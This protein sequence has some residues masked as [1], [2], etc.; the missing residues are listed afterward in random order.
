MRTY[1]EKYLTFRKR[2]NHIVEAQ[3]V[4]AYWGEVSQSYGTL[5]SAA[6]TDGLNRTAQVQFQGSN[7]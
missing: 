3:P 6:G 7:D 4:G 2:G 1:F 5:N